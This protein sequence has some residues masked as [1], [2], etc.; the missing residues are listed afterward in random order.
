MA[1]AGTAGGAGRRRRPAVQ[2]GIVSWGEWCAHDTLPGVYARV[3]AF[4]RWI[5]ETIQQN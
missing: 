1:T 3:S 2:V 5:E 4:K